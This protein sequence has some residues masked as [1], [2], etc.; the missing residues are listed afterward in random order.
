MSSDV[1]AAAKMIHEE[2]RLLH[3]K[4]KDLEGQI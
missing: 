2:N 4:L 3:K 1:N